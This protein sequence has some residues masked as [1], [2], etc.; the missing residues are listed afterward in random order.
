VDESAVHALFRTFESPPVLMS[1][2]CTPISRR[3]CAARRSRRRRSPTCL[4]GCWS[5][6]RALPA[7]SPWEFATGP[8]PTRTRS[9]TP[10]GARGE[11]CIRRL[12]YGALILALLGGRRD[13]FDYAEAYQGH[14]MDIDICHYS[15]DPAFIGASYG[16]SPYHTGAPAVS[17]E[18]AAAGLFLLYYLTGD[19]DARTAAVGIADWLQATNLGLGQGSGRAVGWPLRSLAVAYEN[20]GDPRYL[21]SCKQLAAYAVQSLE[22]RRGFFSEMPATWNYRGGVSTMN[23]ILASGLMHYWRIS[24]DA[25]AGRACANIAYNMAYSW[26]SPTEPGLILGADPLQTLTLTGYAMQDIVPIFWG[27]S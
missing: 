5:R 24:G 25:A 18:C 26:M 21:E 14:F 15:P 27:V 16:I 19:P 3:L 13:W 1:A 9:T 23:A 20:T 10:T 12:D 22:S 4:T 17:A 8:T 2:E 6:S 7:R 11:I